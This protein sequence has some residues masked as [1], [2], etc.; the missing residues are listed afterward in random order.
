MQINLEAQAERIFHECEVLEDRLPVLALC[1][2]WAMEAKAWS[3]ETTEEKEKESAIV[4]M[5]LSTPEVR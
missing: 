2:V 3:R 5:V 4:N 1:S